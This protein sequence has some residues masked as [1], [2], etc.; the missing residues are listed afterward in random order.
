MWDSNPQPRVLETVALTNWA[1]VPF[2]LLGWFEQPISGIAVQ[3]LNQ[4]DYR[5]ICGW[6]KNRTSNLSNSRRNSDLSPNFHLVLT[7]VLPKL[8]INNQPFELKDGFEP[9][10]SGIAVQRL[11]NSA[12]WAFVGERGF[13][14]LTSIT[15]LPLWGIRISNPSTYFQSI[16]Q[17]LQSSVTMC[18]HTFVS[19]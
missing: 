1:N 5:S 2:E 19:Q 15:T 13:P 17:V 6:W 14:P 4:L 18:N 3:R 12:T 10:C 8:Q 16:P 9:P 7:A 11:T